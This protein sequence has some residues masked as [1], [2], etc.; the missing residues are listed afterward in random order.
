M[1]YVLK[2]TGG[3]HGAGG[4][5][6]HTAP[7]PK[8]LAGPRSSWYHSHQHS[9][10]LY[11]VQILATDP[12]LTSSTETQPGAFTAHEDEA[13]KPNPHWASMG[14]RVPPHTAREA[15]LPWALHLRKLLV[16][17]A[18]VTLGSD[19]YSNWLCCSLRSAAP[20]HTDTGKVVGTGCGLVSQRSCSA[21]CSGSLWEGGRGGKAAR[22]G[23]G[24]AG[25]LHSPL[26]AFPNTHP[27]PVA[28]PRQPLSSQ[29]TRLVSNYHSDVLRPPC[30]ELG[31]MQGDAGA[32]GSGASGWE[33]GP[34]LWVLGEGK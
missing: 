29:V 6:D 13:L 20:N 18:E 14:L 10:R 11:H 5:R 34:H 26:P 19:V 1:S 2:A 15:A 23:R 9:R 21:C 33:D 17:P 25:P 12:H 16:G 22:L 28:F 31:A 30:Q 4:L 7:P 24:D 27:T 32:P 8:P 3:S